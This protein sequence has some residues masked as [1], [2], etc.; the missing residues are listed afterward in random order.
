LIVVLW[1]GL[2]LATIQFMRHSPLRVDE[3]GN[4][5]QM[6]LFA[7]GH[8]ELDH[9]LSM[10]PGY[11]LVIAQVLRLLHSESSTLV[12]LLNVFLGIGCV[13]LFAKSYRLLAE[14]H[15]IQ[16]VVQFAMFP[17]IYPF[18]YM[19]YTEIPSLILILAGLYLSLLRRHVLA[20][21]VLTISLTVRQNN[22]IWLV[23]VPA[24]IWLRQTNL[25]VSR[26]NLWAFVRQ[27]WLL[28]PGLLAFAAFVYINGGVATG[29]RPMHPLVLSSGNV[30]FALFLYCLMF[31]PVVIARTRDNV[32]FTLGQ[33]HIGLYLIGFFA[34]YIFTF[35]NTHP[36]NQLLEPDFFLH[37]AVVMTV[38]SNLWLKSLFFL[39]ILLAS[40]DLARSMHER[41]LLVPLALASIA[42]LVPSW[43]IEPRYSVIPF[44]LLL[45][46]RP[47]GPPRA[48]LLT[49]LLCCVM[50]I[51]VVYGIRSG[52]FFL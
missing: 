20:A 31:F 49:T 14:D 24:L 46:L 48:E 38:T 17:T 4:F 45:L 40:L 43:M 51:G 41:P 6:Q 12:R 37:N 27:Y 22:V 16:R 50:S 5:R 8:Y 15:G 21:V 34:L 23:A 29:D 30:F 44:A 36:Y 39:P 19:I 10:I 3:G 18:Y 26:G 33:R 13:A 7:A 9:A 2:L 1:L 11:H 35:V 42:F 32:R 28:A 25:E 52:L 47:S